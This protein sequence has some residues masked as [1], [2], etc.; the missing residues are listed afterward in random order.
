MATVTPEM[1]FEYFKEEDKDITIDDMIERFEESV[2]N[3]LPS[4]HVHVNM[5]FIKENKDGSFSL[6][7]K[8]RKK[9]KDDEESQKLERKKLLLDIDMMEK[10]L[11]EFPVTKWMARAGFFISAGLLL[12]ELIKLA[13]G[14]G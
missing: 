3:F 6:T 9:I 13:V 12:L 11:K 4:V 5:G 14:K 1:I 7:D 2:I 8:A 10:V